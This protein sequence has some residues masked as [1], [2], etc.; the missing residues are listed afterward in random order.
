M[1]HS[2]E[3]KRF[4]V[5]V[6]KDIN[7]NVVYVGSGTEKRPSLKQRTNNRE[8]LA[9]IKELTPE[10]ICT[11]LSKDESIIK[12][13]ELY[14]RYKGNGFLLNKMVPVLMKPI[15][16]DVVSKY[17]YYDPTSP[18]FLRWKIDIPSG[19]YKTTIKTKAGDVAGTIKKSG[20]SETK[21]LGTLYKNHRII[22]VL[23]NK[24]DL[25]CNL[26]VDHID[27]NKSNNSIENL[28][29]VTQQQNMS[30]IDTQ[31]ASETGHKGIYLKKDVHLVYATWLENR[32]QRC[33]TFNYRKLFPNLPEEVSMKKCIDI[34]FWYREQM[35]SFANF[36]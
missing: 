26:V 11:D 23:C 2:E 1:D 6:L 31:T 20:Y 14:F 18:T 24:C 7:G 25:K 9:V 32:Q 34:A 5:Y 17:L 19:R 13:R 36:N 33:K 12:E 21:L 3:D 15:E 4:C 27:R 30:N 29:L 8:L 22:W 35:S 10:I 16:Y 28:R